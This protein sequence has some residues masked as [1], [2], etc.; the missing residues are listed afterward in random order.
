MRGLAFILALILAQTVIAQTRTY[1][2]DDEL[3][4]YSATYD[5]KRFTPAQ[6]ANT[7]KL[8]QTAGSLSLSTNTVAWKFSDI[9]G[10]DLAALDREYARELAEL[11]TLDIV[12]VPYWQTFRQRKIRE[13]EQFYRLSRVTMLGYRNPSALL[14]YTGAP[15][16]TTRY[17]RP[18]VSGGQDLLAVWRMVNE[19]SRKNNADPE[20]IRRIYDEQLRSPERMH[21]ALVEVM[22]FG[23]WNCAN[24]SIDHVPGDETPAREFRKLFKRTRTIRC[25]EP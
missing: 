25:D 10:L 21:F 18:L 17:A 22:N 15:A 14:D 5:S 8:S 3:C 1:R 23:W 19:D 24:A 11:K 16:C 4:Q 12:R 2:W 13:L 7:L 9:A 20:R 6:L